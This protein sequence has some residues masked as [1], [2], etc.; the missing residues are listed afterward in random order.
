MRA[1][2]FVTIHVAQSLDGRLAI[3]GSTT[4]L[5]T[6]EGRA[7]AHAARAAHD[8]VLVG[9]S[10]VKIDDPRLTVRAAKGTDPLR[11]VLCSTLALPPKARVLEGPH[12]SGSPRSLVIGAE[13]IARDEE[14]R[15]LEAAGV[16]VAIAPRSEDGRV[17]IGGAVAILAE[18]GVRR[19]LVEGGGKVVTSFLRAR[20]VDAL[21]MEIA[22]R[23]LGAPGTPTLGALGVDTVDCAPALANVVVERL[24]P[25]VLLR[26]DVVHPD[27]G[28]RSS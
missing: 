14:R 20:A 10:T 28:E 16:A 7:Y 19:L 27:A 11:V 6:P 1:R 26:G 5:S 21:S 22:M 9:S 18:R 12:P 4:L 3:E 15:A 25:S 17:S 23:M 13:G 2:P 8:A 24:G